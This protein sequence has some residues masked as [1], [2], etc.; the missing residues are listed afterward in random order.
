VFLIPTVN[1]A[2]FVQKLGFTAVSMVSNRVGGWGLGLK[3]IV[4]AA[5][6]PLVLRMPSVSYV[7]NA[8]S[9]R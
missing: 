7:L 2:L 3:L 5:Y 4:S 6:P 8:D 9:G 1:G